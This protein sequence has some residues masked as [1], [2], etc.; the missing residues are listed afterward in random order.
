[1]IEPGH[2]GTQLSFPEWCEALLASDL[3]QPSKASFKP[4]G[5][6]TDLMSGY[7]ENVRRS[8]ID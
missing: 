6:G 2:N 3:S 1:M 7:V 4:D 5:M 8:K